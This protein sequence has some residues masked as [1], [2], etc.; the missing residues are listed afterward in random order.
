[1]SAAARIHHGWYVVAALFVILT[2]TSGLAFYNLSVYMNALVAG[3]DFPV[4]AVSVAIAVFF[5]AS[6]LGGL[7]AG[8]LL[9]R[10][11]P[12]WTIVAG[13]VLGALA[14]ALLGGVERLG[15]LYGVYALF[16]LGHACCT[17]VP[18]T[19]LVTGWF[20]AR[21]AIALSIASTGLSVGGILVT[22]ASAALIGRIGLG[23]ATELFALA[24][25][26]GVVP[27]TLLVVRAAPS[28][29]P[30]AEGGVPAA[31]VDGW[32]RGD[33]LS[34]S[35]FLAITGAWSL[36]MLAQVGAISHLFNLAATRVD[37]ATGATAISLMASA[38]ILGRFLGGWLITRM[39]IRIFALGCI[40][41]QGVSLTLLALADRSGAVL[42]GALAFG[43][44]VGNL[45]MLQ[46]LLLAEV[47]G[48]RDYGRI[49][50]TSQLVTTLGV[51]AGPALLGVLFDLLGSYTA[52][53]GLAAAAS[54]LALGA[55]VLAGPFPA[56]PPGGDEARGLDGTEEA[57]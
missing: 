11:D 45:L 19:T 2:I 37:A 34:S 20:R 33:A 38:S 15:E 10:F 35:W 57:A 40:V 6:G 49:Y 53:F 22:P 36:I 54:T 55:M 9:A 5:V 46:P 7:L 18:A 24:W 52:A 28:G 14:L 30:G 42:L 56:G 50:S 31:P 12:R 47:F 48:A 17:L 43:A 27:V 23:P 21:R 25:L 29:T 39:D 13:G 3:R 4:T 8:H 51:A 26:L 1:M 44:T 16:G 41:A 32:T